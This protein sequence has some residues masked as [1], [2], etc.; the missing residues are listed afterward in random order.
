MNA[1][2]GLYYNIHNLIFPRL[3]HL[4]GLAPLALRLY[5][6]PVFWMAGTQKISGIDSTIEWFGNPDWGLGLPMPW[7]MA[8][9]ATSAELVGAFLLDNLFI[10]QLTDHFLVLHM[11]LFRG[12]FEVRNTFRT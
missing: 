1:I 3:Q 9:L 5:L 6:V 2:A 7:L 8:F 11:M 12:L 4:D 10:Q